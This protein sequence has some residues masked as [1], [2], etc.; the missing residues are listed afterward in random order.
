MMFLENELL[1]VTI[2][3]Q[4]AELKSV[5]NKEN[6]LEYLW[7][8][9]PLFWNRSAPHLF[10]IVGELKN[11]SYL[12]EGK[13]YKLPR[14]GFIRNLHPAVLNQQQHA[15]EFE[16]CAGEDTLAHF[17]FHF[18]LRIKYEL[19]GNE[20]KTTY[21]IFNPD[22]KTL[23]YSLGAHPGFKVHTKLEDY[24]IEFELDEDTDRYFVRQ[25]LIANHYENFKTQNRN[26]FLKKEFFSDDALVFKNL[27]SSGVK[28]YHVNTGKGVVVKWD[29]KF[30]YFGIWTQPDCDEFLCLEPWAGIA[31]HSNFQQEFKFK[32]GIRALDAYGSDQFE[33]SYRFV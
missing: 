31:D 5:Y 28:L 13:T 11:G 20:I 15:V 19:S 9:D 32:E 16:F 14:H 7:N 2:G 21:L 25:G 8:G 12:H 17:P 27:N 22:S 10:P 30:S 6:R 23:F 1:K 29:K 24:A 3:L 26:L 18:S 4:G 33:L